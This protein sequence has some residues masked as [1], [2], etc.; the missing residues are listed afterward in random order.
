MAAAAGFRAAARDVL[1]EI[2]IN[3]KNTNFIR[4]FYPRLSGLCSCQ[5]FNAN[6][7]SMPLVNGGDFWPIQHLR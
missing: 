6:A 1:P 5:R 3:A 4:I 7:N 2:M